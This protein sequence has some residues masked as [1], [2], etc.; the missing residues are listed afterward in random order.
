MDYKVYGYKTSEFTGK[1][2][3]PNY[4]TCCMKPNPGLDEKYLSQITYP[5]GYKR[6]TTETITM[7]YPICD[8]CLKHRKLFLKQK[9][10]YT[11]TIC[12]SVIVS[13]ILPLT[14][15]LNTYETSAY[16][17]SGCTIVS[18]IVMFIARKKYSLD[19]YTSDIHSHMCGGV[20]IKAK[21]MGLTDITFYN[22]NY[23]IANQELS[24][25]KHNSSKENKVETTDKFRFF[26]WYKYSLVISALSFAMILVLTLILSNGNYSAWKLN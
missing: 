6:S 2:S 16:I 15:E 24:Y 10:V 7:N 8:D 21:G 23:Y 1:K 9:N 3:I 13:C 17:I 11:L 25:G 18:L 12:L 19:E 20:E 5:S 14:L 26:N 22:H 4:C